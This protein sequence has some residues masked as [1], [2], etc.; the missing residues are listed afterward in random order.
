MS[1]ESLAAWFPIVLRY[2]GLAGCLL[3]VPIVWLLTGRLAGELIGMFTAMW[4]LGEGADA[5]REFSRSAPKAPDPLTPST[6]PE[7]G[8]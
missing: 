8:A 5:L 7:D 6:A 1:R 2:G 3:F 4:G